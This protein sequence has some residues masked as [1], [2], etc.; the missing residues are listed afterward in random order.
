MQRARPRA[1]LDCVLWNGSW[2]LTGSYPMA[3]LHTTDDPSVGALPNTVWPEAEAVHRPRQG[4]HDARHG[5]ASDGW[6]W[7]VPWE[8]V[9]GKHP[10]TSAHLPDTVPGV[11]SKRGGRT[12]ERWISPMRWTTP[13]LNGSEGAD[14]SAWGAALGFGE[15]LRPT[16][17]E[18]GGVRWLGTDEVAENRGEC[19]S[20][21]LPEEDT[22]MV[23]MRRSG[24]PPS[25][26]MHCVEA[27]RAAP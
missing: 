6:R 7:D 21:G 9:H 16:Y 19:G 24:W 2:W 4:P 5:G 25:I 10:W 14:P 11:E 8:D 1:R 22:A 12:M 27:T 13:E 3:K 17:G 18:R 23:Q 15:A 26:A 20:D